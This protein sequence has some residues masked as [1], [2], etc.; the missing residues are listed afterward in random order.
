MTRI[1]TERKG[2]SNWIWIVLLLLLLVALGWWFVGR[3]P[4][5]DRATMSLPAD[6]TGMNTGAGP[7]V[8]RYLAFADSARAQTN[9]GPDHSYSAEGVR[10]LADAIGELTIRDTVAG[11]ATT[12]QV[13]ALKT[14]ADRL[15]ADAQ[16]LSHADV[17]HAA[18]TSAAAL[19]GEVQS[20]RFPNRAGEIEAV[21]S[22][23]DAI[24]KDQPLLEQK[25]RVDTF[26]TRA[27]EVLRFMQTPS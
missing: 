14:L 9:A 16:S 12:T 24:A 1:D 5:L 13:A 4:A 17:F 3:P 23:A 15:Q 18:A 8:A 22:A 27:A 26:F 10:L 2:T 6:S 21:R 20:R 19:M 25:E 11:A 7:A